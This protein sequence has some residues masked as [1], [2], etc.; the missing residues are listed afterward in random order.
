MF[1]T[2]T[3]V[4]VT[5]FVIGAVCIG[6]AVALGGR[7]IAT[8]GW[9]ASDWNIDFGDGYDPK[10]WDGPEIT[11][12]IPWDGSNELIIAHGG[13]VNF[14]Q[15]PEHK[16]VVTGPEGAVNQLRMYDGKLRLGDHP[17]WSRG[18]LRVDVTAPDLDTFKI[19]GSSHLRIANY[20]QPELNVEINGNGDV[21]AVGKAKDISVEI[22]GSGDV[23]LGKIESENARVEIMGSGDTTIAPTKSVDID[24]AGSGDVTLLTD[25]PQVE[26]DIKGSGDI[27]HRPRHSDAAPATPSPSPSPSPSASPSP[28]A[29]PT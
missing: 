20:D 12:E 24:I 27:R 13:D 23:D 8:H 6:G 11:R 15:G 7:D 9:K 28:P 18:R 4:A 16:M 14:T 10:L 5:G 25:P 29:N 26:T 21:D 19:Y 3:I 17:L 2:L 1:R 22:R